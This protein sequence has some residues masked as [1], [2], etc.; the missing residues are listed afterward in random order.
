M[1]TQIKNI[2][3]LLVIILILVCLFQSCKTEKELY[4]STSFHEPATQGLRFIYS[5]DG[6]KWDSVPGVW[7]KPEIGVQQVLRDPSIVRSPDGIFHLVWTSSWKGDLGFGYANSKDLINWS[8]PVLIPVMKN[9]PSTVNVWAPE[10]FFDDKK[11][12]FVIVWASCIPNR[13]PDELEDNNNNHRLYYVTTKDFKTISETKLF[14]D[15][16]FSSID[17]TIV[18]RAKNDYVLV[19]KDN[20]R[21]NRNLKVAFANSA[22]GPYSEPSTA[23][24]DNFVE[25]PTVEKIADEYVIYFDEY[26]NF[27]FGA[28]KTKDFIHFTNI[29]SEIKI[30]AGHKHG[31]IFKAPSLIVNGLNKNYELSQKQRKNSSA[32][33]VVTK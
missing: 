8:E 25:G 17:A 1:F 19:F 31:T 4:V 33:E 21:P 24:T 11:N 20:T 16:G 9:E 10:L 18:K 2:Y 14:Y 29:S 27:S 28:V 23:F 5:I 12:E 6:L 32:K 30:P 13:F 7:L 26:R 3:K 22:T 15:P